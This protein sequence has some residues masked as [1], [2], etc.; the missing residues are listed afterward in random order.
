[1]V[2]NACNKNFKD[3]ET[4]WKMSLMTCNGNGGDCQIDTKCDGNRSQRNAIK[5]K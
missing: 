4:K 1:M 5:R 3:P 2:C